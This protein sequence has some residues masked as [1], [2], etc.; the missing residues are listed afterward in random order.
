MSSKLRADSEID[1]V[2][3]LYLK[4]DKFKASAFMPIEKTANVFYQ[5]L[6]IIDYVHDIFII[7]NGNRAP[8]NNDA[9]FQTLKKMTIDKIKTI[10]K[11]DLE[12]ILME[13]DYI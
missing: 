6:A 9:D 10:K 3:K 11:R 8:K 5:K 13:Y 2:A 7:K 1:Q 12:K 4:K